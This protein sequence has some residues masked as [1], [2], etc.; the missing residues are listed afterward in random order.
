VHRLFVALR[1][2]AAARRRLL[3]VMDG[4]P[5]ARWQDDDQ[6]HLTLRFV[7]EVDARQA[8][9]LAAALGRVTHPRPTV[10][11]AGV[12]AFASRGQPH[13][14]W[15]GVA[16]DEALRLLQ[17]RVER[18]LVLAGVAPERRA[19]APHVT[20]ARLGRTAGP[21]DGFLQREAGLALAAEVPDHFLL[22]ESELGR[23]GAVYHA[24]ARYPLAGEGLAPAAALL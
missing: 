19:F 1:P 24:V 7:G 11:L 22:Y 12:G 15:A 14:L 21:L 10:R 16:P 5:G 17:R 20:L 3:R 6:L 8:D 23:H 13:T 18:A 2:S 4:V 9:D